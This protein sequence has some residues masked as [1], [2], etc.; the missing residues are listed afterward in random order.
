MA[1]PHT[2]DVLVRTDFGIFHVCRFC[3]GIPAGVSVPVKP[4]LRVSLHFPGTVVRNSNYTER[5]R[6]CQCENI[7]HDTP[8]YHDLSVPLSVVFGEE[9]LALD[10]ADR[11]L[12][13]RDVTEEG[14]VSDL[15]VYRQ[16][17]GRGNLEAY[18]LT[19]RVRFGKV[20]R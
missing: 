1:C 16:N 2:E 15:V 4:G 10:D 13:I 5:L 11:A 6:P 8:R 9:W 7:A 19:Q 12:I 18:V 3:A 17:I 20:A 14:G